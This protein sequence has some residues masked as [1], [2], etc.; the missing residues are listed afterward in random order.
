MTQI[1]IAQTSSTFISRMY[2]RLQGVPMGQRL[3]SKALC[4]KAPFFGT[5]KPE[6]VR[7]SPGYAEWKIKNRRSVHNHIGT[8]HAIAMCNLAKLCAG[9]ALEMTIPK[10]LRW[11][12][13]GM[14]VQYLQKATSDLTGACTIETAVEPGELSVRVDISNEDGDL[15]FKAEINIWISEKPKS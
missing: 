4:L 13:K 11:I 2:N 8:V 1:A 10:H 6:V 12:P 15:V 3:F 9:T 14:S 5:I 7:L